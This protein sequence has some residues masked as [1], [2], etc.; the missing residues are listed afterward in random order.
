MPTSQVTGMRPA[1]PWHYLL[2]LTAGTLAGLGFL[3]MLTIGPLLMLGAAAVAGLGV[4]RR[5]VNRS[6]AALPA[7]LSVAVLYLAWLNKDGPGDVCVSTNAGSSC[8][9]EWDPL[10]ILVAGALVLVA[11]VVLWAVLR[12]I[13][14][15]A[16]PP[17]GP[18]VGRDA[19]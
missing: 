1:A 13:Q 8:V 2:W 6:L 17:A 10:P 19:V 3:A 18:P 15:P 11:A 4:H 5:L 12:R 14:E 9:E 7:G 16:P